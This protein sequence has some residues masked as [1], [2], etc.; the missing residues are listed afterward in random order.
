M[1]EL[2]NI[3]KEIDTIDS[4]IVGLFRKR[5]ELSGEV[6]KAKADS[7]ARIND[8]ARERE[9]LSRIA[10]KD[11]EFEMYISGLYKTV[12]EL[13]KT[14]Q[15]ALINSKSPL[16]EKLEAMRDARLPLLPERATIACQ[17]VEGAYSQLA[18]EK[19]FRRGDLMFVNSF[20]AVFDA[21]DKGLCE[22][23]VLPID[24]STNGSV[25]Q[26][27]DLMIKKKFYIT[28]ATKL[29]V[30]HE[31]LAK[32]GTSL[33][34]ISAVCSHEQGLQQC[35]GFLSSLPE[36][37]EI[38]TC[39]NTAMAA[40][41][42]SESSGKIAAISSHAC[43]EIYDLE[44][45]SDDIQN[46]EN[47]YTKFIVITKQ[48]TMYEGANHINLLLTLDH[49]PGALYDTISKFAILGINLTNL[50]SHPIPG[51]DFEFMFF[52]ELEASLMDDRVIKMLTA[53]ETSCDEFQFL[54]N[55]IMI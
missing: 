21:V 29:F 53:L 17:G 24:N 36:E 48:P 3:R 18:A 47:N 11:D 52:F 9:I 43:G 40:R 25:K 55:Y 33:S 10:K 15:S 34:E 27:Y 32:K 28:A 6:A 41:M 20:E 8:P 1:T 13:S 30:K 26:V 35:S 22:F 4:E 46:S 19:F 51:Q 54:G 42:V 2:K 5:M 31:L 49:R 45:I 38:I 44:C 7:S 12:F 14:Y 37:V 16:G 39:D 23:G 50:E